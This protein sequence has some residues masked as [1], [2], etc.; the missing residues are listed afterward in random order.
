MYVFFIHARFYQ[1]VKF[2]AFEDINKIHFALNLAWVV[3]LTVILAGYI[4]IWNRKLEIAEFV[5]AFFAFHKK[6][7]GIVN[8]NIIFGQLVP[9]DPSEILKVF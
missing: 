7:E 9:R 5:N 8:H 1:L 4:S 2:N 3:G 6:V